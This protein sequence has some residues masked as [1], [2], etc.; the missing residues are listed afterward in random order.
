[1]A[2][3]VFTVKDFSNEL[4]TVAFPVTEPAQ[5]GSDYQNL[6]VTQYNALKTALQAATIGNVA[7]GRMVARETVENSDTPTNAYAQ[8]ELGARLYYQT[9]GP[10]GKKGYITIPAPSDA[11]IDNNSDELDITNTLL[12]AIITILEVIMRVDGESVN[13]YRGRLVGR[14]S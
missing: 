8:R 7:S 13:F 9:T 2:Q 11:V 14:R 6:A 10:L 5:D 3:I 4:S 12:A 1:M